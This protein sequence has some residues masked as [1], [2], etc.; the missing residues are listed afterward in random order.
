MGLCKSNDCCTDMCCVALNMYCGTYS[1]VF[2]L[3][4]NNYSKKHV[5]FYD[6]LKHCNQHFLL[7]IKKLAL[8]I[9]CFVVLMFF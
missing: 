2:I 9:M 7:L 3:L 5:D 8:R 6:Y 1:Q 4:T